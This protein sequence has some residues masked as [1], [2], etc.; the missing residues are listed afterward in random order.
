MA[1][2]INIITYVFDV[3]FLA[4]GSFFL[5]VFGSRIFL[6]DLSEARAAVS[7]SSSARMLLLP[8]GVPP[9]SPLSCTEFEDEGV[10]VVDGG[11]GVNA[12]AC[13]DA[14]RSGL[15]LGFRVLVPFLTSH[16]EHLN[17]SALFLNV[18]TL[19]SQ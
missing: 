17:A 9:S 7:V 12:C 14:T 18:H 6:F 15:I 10:G 4:P 1:L 3:N 19:Q 5:V 16:I 2:T 8:G 13:C 11:G